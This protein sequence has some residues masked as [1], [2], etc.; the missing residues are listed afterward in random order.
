MILGADSSISSNIA[1]T[2]SNL[3]KIMVLTD[4]FPYPD[5]G[6]DQRKI[7]VV[8][9]QQPILAAAA[10]NP[11]DADRLLSLL[12][13]HCTIQE[14]G[15]GNVGCDVEFI[16]ADGDQ[17]YGHDFSEMIGYNAEQVAHLARGEIWSSLRS[18]QQL[19]ICLLVAGL[20]RCQAV[21][22]S[23]VVNELSAKNDMV[24]EPRLFWIDEYG[25]LQKIKYGSHGFG[26]NF[27]LSILDEGYREDM[28]RKEAI[29]LVRECFRQLRHRYVINSPQPPCIKCVSVDGCE[30]ILS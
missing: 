9:R 2:A 5:N 25:S 26:S 1:L 20:C 4:P 23:S 15:N 19:R 24:L 27:A 30:L 22:C 10:G 6:S 11:A 18:R 12:S 29:E 16:N 28:S 13:A 14:Y 8:H 17:E 21:A 7:N 3:D